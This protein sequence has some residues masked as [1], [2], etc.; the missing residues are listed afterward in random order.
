MPLGLQHLREEM[1]KQRE[2]QHETRVALVAG[3]PDELPHPRAVVEGL[4]VP[5]Q[6]AGLLPSQD[7]LL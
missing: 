4:D 5:E 7:G 2:V 1:H 6:R 3:A